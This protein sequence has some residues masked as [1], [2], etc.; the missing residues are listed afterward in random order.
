VELEMKRLVPLVLTLAV[1]GAGLAACTST[2]VPYAYGYA[3][4]YYDNFYGPFSNGYW[5]PDGVFYYQKYKDWDYLRD[6]GGHFRHEMASG[7][8]A[9]HTWSVLPVGEALATPPAS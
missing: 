7:Y 4:G 2:Y 3:N 5:G 6:Q 1:T 8:Q 9:F